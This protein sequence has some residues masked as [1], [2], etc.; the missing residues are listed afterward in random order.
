[1]PGFRTCHTGSACFGATARQGRLSSFF[2]WGFLQRHSLQ[3]QACGGAHTCG[4]RRGSLISRRFPSSSSGQFMPHLISI[5][6]RSLYSECEIRASWAGPAINVRY[7]EFN[8]LFCVNVVFF[9]WLYLFH[10]CLGILIF[11]ISARQVPSAGMCMGSRHLCILVSSSS[12]TW[13]A[14]R[15]FGTSFA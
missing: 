2:K 5:S 15:Y 4:R 10:G 6:P 11:M 9:F 1:M 13:L 7:K 3:V 8:L 12:L 14:P